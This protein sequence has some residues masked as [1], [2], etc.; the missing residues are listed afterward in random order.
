[1]TTAFV[2]V[3]GGSGS[4]LGGAVPKA[5]ADLEGRTLLE[6]AFAG[7]QTEA[8]FAHGIVVAPADWCGTARQQLAPILRSGLQQTSY[9][10]IHG[11]IAN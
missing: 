7:L 4:R 9:R 1:M 2:L 6:R 11:K 10:I 8:R 3:A 5:F